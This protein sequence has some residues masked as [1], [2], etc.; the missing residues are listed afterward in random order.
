MT[1]C[2]PEFELVLSLTNLVNLGILSDHLTREK[3]TS[4]RVTSEN[5]TSQKSLI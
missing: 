1:Y 3:A 4:K 5:L 2:T